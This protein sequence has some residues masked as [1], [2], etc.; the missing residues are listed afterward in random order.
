VG[1]EV[2][3]GLTGVADAGVFLARLTRLD[4]RALVRLRPAGVDRTALW[5]RL[6]WEALVT[7]SVPGQLSQ[8]VTVLAA[9]LLAELAREGPELPTRRDE[10]W[11][12]PLPPAGQQVLER[13]PVA[14]VREIGAAAEGTVRAAAHGGV[15]G[16][17][18][19]DRV[20]RDALLDH[21]AI[22]VRPDVAGDAGPDPGVEA[23][24]GAIGRDAEAGGGAIGR[25]AEAGG[26]DTA[27]DSVEVPQRLIQAVIR[28]GFLGGVPDNG[29]V[30]V[31]R[32]ATWV[33]LAAQ[34]GTAWLRP[35]GSLVVRRPT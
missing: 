26:G 31:L 15:G 34:Y 16:R 19:G 9:D 30:R 17:A 32:A 29:Q 24:G 23:G 4:P 18:V 2:G 11:R 6:P 14:A 13:V 12:W 3:H 27:L 21:V 7:R 8:D 5:A 25:D 1:R 10:Q 33:G 28:M 22:R 35:A 20:V